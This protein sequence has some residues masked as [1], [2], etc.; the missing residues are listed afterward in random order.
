MG[1]DMGVSKGSF[2]PALVVVQKNRVHSK[3]TF[4]LMHL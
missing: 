4:L 1:S 2:P 3:V